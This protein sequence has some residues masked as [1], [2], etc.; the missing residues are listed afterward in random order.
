MTHEWAEMTS[1]LCARTA[2]TLYATSGVKTMSTWVDKG[3]SVC[4][5][6]SDPRET[7]RRQ[8]SIGSTPPDREIF[9][10]LTPIPL[11]N[12]QKKQATKPRGPSMY[13]FATPKSAIDSGS[14]HIAPNSAVLRRSSATHFPPRFLR[15][16]LIIR[17]EARPAIG[18][19]TFFFC[20][21]VRI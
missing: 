18:A 3:A 4:R 15:H 21:V 13:A 10:K 16:F 19:P 1:A 6:S 9:E 17:S 7:L 12:K 5:V 14:N 2:S 8:T 11:M 20:R